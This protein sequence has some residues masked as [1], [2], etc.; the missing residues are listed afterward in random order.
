MGNSIFFN[1]FPKSVGSA[2]SLSRRLCLEGEN[3]AWTSLCLTFIFIPGWQCW[4][5]YFWFWSIFST[6]S[7]EQ[8]YYDSTIEVDITKHPIRLSEVFAT[9]FP[10]EDLFRENTDCLLINLL[11]KEKNSSIWKQS[12]RIIFI[13][14]LC[15]QVEIL[16]R[17]QMTYFLNC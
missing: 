2:F 15:I 17:T 16:H 12:I 13:L 4:S 9:I 10:P 11:G 7:G 8:K 14:L 6:V 5:L 1:T 3:N